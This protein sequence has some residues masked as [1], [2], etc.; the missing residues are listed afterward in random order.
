MRQTY[1]KPTVPEVLLKDYYALPAF[2][3]ELLQV[4][5]VDAASCGI[6][7]IQPFI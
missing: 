3:S 4:S 6:T 1:G 5:L 7:V 2:T